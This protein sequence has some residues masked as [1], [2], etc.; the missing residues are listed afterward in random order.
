[1]LAQSTLLSLGQYLLLLPVNS[2]STLWA[3]NIARELSMHIDLCS[4][5]AHINTPYDY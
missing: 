3:V 2:Y 5:I 4:L 1:M